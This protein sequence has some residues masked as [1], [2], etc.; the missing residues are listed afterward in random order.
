MCDASNADKCFIVSITPVGSLLRSMLEG[1]QCTDCGCQV[2]DWF[3]HNQPSLQ[4]RQILW[5]GLHCL[6]YKWIFWTNILCNIFWKQNPPEKSVLY[7]CLPIKLR[8]WIMVAKSIEYKQKEQQ[9]VTWLITISYLLATAKLTLKLPWQTAFFIFLLKKRIN[10]VFFLLCFAC[11]P[12][13]V[14][15]IHILRQKI[16]VPNIFAPNLLDKRQ[17]IYSLQVF[18]VVEILSYRILSCFNIVLKIRND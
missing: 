4:K 1:E 7:W 3:D 2:F 6:L 18:V 5:P 12:V 10:P 14:K 13:S 15:I 11:C 16:L 17:T 8:Y 9:S